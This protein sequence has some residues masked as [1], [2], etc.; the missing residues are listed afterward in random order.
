MLVQVMIASA[1]IL[2]TTVVH[3]GGTHVAPWGLHWNRA[4]LWSVGSGWRKVLFIAGAVML[5]FV[6][7]LIEIGLWAATF[8]QIRALPDLDTAFYFS[9][10]TYVSLGYGDITL[11]RSW[12]LLSALEGANGVI[13][14]GWSTAVVFAF[15]REVVVEDERAGSP[16]GLQ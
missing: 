12:R 11:E 15:V 10:V 5:M 4:E 7:S 2:V 14:F 8:L 3:A 13:L 16:R 9:A 6:A 1:L